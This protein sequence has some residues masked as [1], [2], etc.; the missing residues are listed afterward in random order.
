M[1]LQ[2]CSSSRKR[3][4]ILDILRDRYTALWLR[5][6]LLLRRNLLLLL[7]ICSIFRASL[8]DWLLLNRREGSGPLPAWAIQL[9]STSS[10]RQILDRSSRRR[11]SK[12]LLWLLLA[13]S[14]KSR[15]LDTATGYLFLLIALL[16]CRR[17]RLVDRFDIAN[18]LTCH[19][20]RH[21]AKVRNEMRAIRVTR[22]TAFCTSSCF[23]A[24]KRNNLTTVAAPTWTEGGDGLEAMGNAVVDLVAILIL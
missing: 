21:S 17:A 9:H 1:R 24:C 12:G 2:R 5:G 22:E 14:A 16:Q 3:V 7:L 23:L 20:H 19:F 4:L 15:W 18:K 13:K 10:I 8:R 11:R 6:S